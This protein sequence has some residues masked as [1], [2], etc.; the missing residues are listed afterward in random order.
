M[1]QRLLNPIRMIRK[2]TGGFTLIEIAIFIV[3]T[4]ILMATLMAPFLT[5]VFRSEQPEI[6]A[7]AAF[8]AGERLEQL[9]G[10]AYASI[11]SETTAA[12]TGNYSAFSRQ[13][14]VTLLDA[15]L[16]VSGSDVGYKRVVVTVYHSQLPAGGIGIT[17]LFTNYA[18]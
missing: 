13:A 12:L 15:S 17:A 18:G 8:L 10:V 7:S 16:N 1:N 6:A 11:V 5:S 4:G 9:Q 3:L 14:A 2:R